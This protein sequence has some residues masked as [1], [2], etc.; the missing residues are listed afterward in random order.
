[1]RHLLLASLAISAATLSPVRA[2]TVDT[3]TFQQPGYA[4]LSG[5]L[6]IPFMTGSFTGAVEPS[7]FIELSDLTSLSMTDNQGVFWSLADLKFFSFDTNGGNSTLGVIA[8][9]GTVDDVNAQATACIGAP[10]A[11]SPVCN[12]NGT[13]AGDLGY[14]LLSFFVLNRDAPF[15]TSTTQPSVT[16]VSSVVTPPAAPTTVP[17]PASLALLAAGLIGLAANRRRQP[18]ARSGG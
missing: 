1:M 15:A 17:E 14:E 13:P 12:P 7:G 5:A 2:T 10:A 9:G 4:Q 16:L 6:P 18:S 8:N 3:F 11:L